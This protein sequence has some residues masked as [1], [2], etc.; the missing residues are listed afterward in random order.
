LKE[1][2]FKQISENICKDCTTIS[3]EIRKYLI[4]KNVGGKVN[5]LMIVFIEKIVNLKKKI[6][7]AID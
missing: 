7:Y 2:L 6:D 3:K 1:K 5:S 4:T